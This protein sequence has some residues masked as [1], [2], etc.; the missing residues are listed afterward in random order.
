[1][2]TLLAAAT[3]LLSVTWV[4][5]QAS[6][7][8]SMPADVGAGKVAK[9]DLTTTDVAKAKDFYGKL[10]GW[11]FNSKP[12]LEALMVEV[13]VDDVQV[14]SIRKAEGP[15]STFNGVVYIQVDDMKSSVQKAQDLGA[16]IPKGFPFDLP[17]GRGSISLVTDPF[18][19]PIGLFSRSS[20]AAATP[21]GK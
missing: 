3:L 12:G 20:L 6:P 10:F 11:K 16:K 7:K 15:I 2:R 1:M 19:H 13:L 4:A 5:Q 18:G 14:G 8:K 9:F 17:D 21:A